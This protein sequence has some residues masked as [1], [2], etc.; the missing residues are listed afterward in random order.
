MRNLTETKQKHKLFHNVKLVQSIQ[1]LA[2][3]SINWNFLGKW[4][5]AEANILGFPE[6][7]A[8]ADNVLHYTWNPIL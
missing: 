5:Q 2:I 6:P 7:L 4:G 3:C 8:L 1:E